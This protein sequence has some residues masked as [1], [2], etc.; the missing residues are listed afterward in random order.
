MPVLNTLLFLAMLQSKFHRFPKHLELNWVNDKLTIP[1]GAFYISS[2]K[3]WFDRIQQDW[4]I[5]WFD[6]E[7]Q[8]VLASLG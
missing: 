6:H 3:T 4:E 5:V 2:G 8:R 7:A 1:D